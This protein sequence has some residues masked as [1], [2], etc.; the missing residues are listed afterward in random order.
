MKG[1]PFKMSDARTRRI[2]LDAVLE[3]CRYRGWRGWV[4]VRTN[5][6]HAVVIGAAHPD[7]MMNDFKAYA[8][9]ALNAG[10]LTEPEASAP[11]V[12]KRRYWTEHGSTR[13]LWTPEQLADKIDYVKNRQGVVLAYGESRGDHRAE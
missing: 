11:G 13:W 4:H 7:K 6:V 9:R 2:V 8:S 10:A 3:V 1:Q 12:G 5:H